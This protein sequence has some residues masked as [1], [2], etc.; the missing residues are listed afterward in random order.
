MTSNGTA[1]PRN[2]RKAVAQASRPGTLS[3][4]QLKLWRS[5]CHAER[6]Y[7]EAPSAELEKQIKTLNAFCQC[8]LAYLSSI[9]AM[10][11]AA[12]PAGEPPYGD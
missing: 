9:K 5:L 7:Q 2:G 3:S 8:A 11:Y 1:A 4:L 10:D 12:H 6:L